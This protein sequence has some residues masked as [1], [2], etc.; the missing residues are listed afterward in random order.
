[1]GRPG[2]GGED[3][4]TESTFQTG[5]TVLWPEGREGSPPRGGE[6]NGV[7]LRGKRI[8]SWGALPARAG[9]K[10]ASAWKTSWIPPV[11][12]RGL[13]PA[14]WLRP[15]QSWP[16]QPGPHMFIE[17]QLC[18][19]EPK[20]RPIW[21]AHT[22]CLAYLGTGCIGGCPLIQVGVAWGKGGAGQVCCALRLTCTR[23]C[24]GRSAVSLPM[25]SCLTAEDPGQ[26]GRAP[27]PRSQGDK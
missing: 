12:D 15:G 6:M 3:R 11:L 7:G 20:A 23:F 2:E 22:D 21:V 10:A 24:L 27:W 14:A 26:G 5:D 25:S 17:V 19:Q 18:V 13:H 4:G 9:L 16:V 8:L 1:M